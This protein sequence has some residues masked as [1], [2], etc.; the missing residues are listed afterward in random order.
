MDRP[1]WLIPI[2]HLAPMTLLRYVR[3]R[4]NYHDPYANGKHGLTHVQQ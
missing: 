1:F 4:Q 3:W 2:Q